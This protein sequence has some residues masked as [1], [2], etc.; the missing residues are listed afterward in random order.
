MPPC[1]PSS[2]CRQDAACAAL[3]GM[4][5]AGRRA[6][7]HRRHLCEQ[8]PG[9]VYGPAHAWGDV[10]ACRDLHTQG[11]GPCGPGCQ[12]LL[13]R[14]Q[15][16]AQQA[17]LASRHAALQQLRR[18]G[19]AAGQR[20]RQAVR[21]RAG[22]RA[23]GLRTGAA[24]AG[25]PPVEAA[26]RTPRS[27][28]AGSVL[29]EGQRRP[30]SAQHAHPR[31]VHAA[32]VVVDDAIEG[33]KHEGVH[34]EVSLGHVAGARTGPRWLAGQLPL[35]GG[36]PESA[37]GAHAGDCRARAQ[38]RG[39]YSSSGG[40]GRGGASLCSELVAVGRDAAP[41]LRLHVE[42]GHLVPFLIKGHPD[43]GEALAHLD[44][45]LEQLL[46]LQPRT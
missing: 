2:S 11:A 16:R 24:T 5:G 1:P 36:D 18:A 44:G 9:C 31:I 38:Q 14:Q 30:H 8:R 35:Q 32:H 13:K 22:R 15:Q 33:V 10:H 20:S 41:G 46:D 6:G 42:G 37:A 34:R 12:S 4:Q 21:C 3:H 43:D 25:A 26:R 7:A 39:L 19:I 45:T 17:L 23:G 29:K 28:R 40:A 27:M